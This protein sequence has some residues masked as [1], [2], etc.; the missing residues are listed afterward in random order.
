MNKIKDKL[1]N[2]SNKQEIHD[3][4]NNIINKVDTSKVL[5]PNDDIY[6]I[7]RK[8]KWVPI[9]LSAIPLTA[10][11]LLGLSIPFITNSVKTNNGSKNNDIDD[12]GITTPAIPFDDSIDFS[13]ISYEEAMQFMSKMEIQ[14]VY[15]IINAANAFSNISTKIKT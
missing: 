8:P 13:N 2:A 5:V 4:T 14:D 10:V 15:N 6:E 3:L 12:P 1:I 9:L 11:F 7:K